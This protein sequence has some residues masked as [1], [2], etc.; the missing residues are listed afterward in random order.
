MARTASV[1]INRKPATPPTVEPFEDEIE[2]AP[3]PAPRVQRGPAA[4]QW[5]DTTLPG[6]GKLRASG[7]LP[8]VLL[9]ACAVALMYLIQTSGVATVGYDVQRLQSESKQWELRNEQL[10]LELAKVR[11]LV[12]VESEAVG[13]MGMVRPDSVTHVQ[14]DS[15]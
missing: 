13:R 5:A 9:S 12:W 10:R 2:Y 8:A 3:S 15:R 7:W 6:I 11:S 4:F 1:I 14:V